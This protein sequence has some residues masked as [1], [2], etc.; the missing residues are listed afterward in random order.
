MNAF[1]TAI[2]FFAELSI[3]TPT[4]YGWFHMCWLAITA[5]SCTLVFCM[6][7]RITQKQVDVTLIVWGT[8]LVFI[9]ILKQ[10]V[11]SFRF[12]NDRVEWSYAWW[13][14]PFQFCSMPL[15]LAIPAG[16]LRQGKTKDALN[17]FLSSYA[18]LGGA[19]A[20]IY[21]A[22][23]FTTSAFI[24]IHTM[25]WHSSMVT[26]CFML[27]ASKTVKPSVKALLRAGIVF[28][29]VTAIAVALNVI[30][31]ECTGV[32]DVNLFFISPYE[33]WKVPIIK[34]VYDAVPYPVYLLLFI[35]AMTAAAALILGAAHGFNKLAE[36]VRERNEGKTA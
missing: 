35:I 28:I 24:S 10:L 11:V 16:A 3:E 19:I 29:I 26:V 15:Y 12:V 5:L 13:A 2:K 36:R 22:N 27:L 20:M 34:L 23:M 25:L 4:L 6:R 33:A 21:P 31:G 30:I 9:E 18:L 8:A 17:S 1:E 32:K 14:F 7:K